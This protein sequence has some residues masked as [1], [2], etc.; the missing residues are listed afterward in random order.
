MASSCGLQWLL[1]VEAVLVVAASSDSCHFPAI[2]NFGDSNF[3]T[4]GLSAAFRAAPSPYDES[5]FVKPVGQYYDGLLLVDFIGTFIHMSQSQLQQHDSLPPSHLQN[6]N[7]IAACSLCLPFLSAYLNSVGTNFSHGANFA[8]A[9]SMIR[10]P[11][12][13]Q[14]KLSQTLVFHRCLFHFRPMSMKP[15]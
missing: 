15:M 12:A 2:F 4:G 13:L 9:G 5:Y 1:L 6:H 14:Q 7:I 11:Y 10:Q 3:D 8:T